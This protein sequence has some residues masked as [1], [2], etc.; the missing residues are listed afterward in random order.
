MNVL[1]QFLAEKFEK[2][3]KSVS[4]FLYV[5]RLTSSQGLPRYETGDVCMM[6]SNFASFS[7]SYVMLLS[8]TAKFTSDL[9]QL[10]L[11]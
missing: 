7:R 5:L 2:V 8:T 6:I 10:P 9:E 3:P 1:L 4:D 11:S